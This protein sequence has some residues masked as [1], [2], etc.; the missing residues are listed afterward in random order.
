MRCVRCNR[1]IKLPESIKHKS[2]KV[3]YEKIKKDIQ[4]ELFKNIKVQSNNDNTI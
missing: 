3:C 4:F 1:L 2:G